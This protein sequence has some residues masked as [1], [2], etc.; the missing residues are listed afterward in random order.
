MDYRCQAA[1]P[2]TTLHCYANFTDHVASMA[3]NNR[4]T[5]NIVFAFGHMDFNKTIFFAID[6]SPK[7]FLQWF[8]GSHQTVINRMPDVFMAGYLATW[9]P[10]PGR[11]DLGNFS[12][13]YDH[14]D[15]DDARARGIAVFYTPDVLTDST[16]ERRFA[17]YSS[18]PVESKQSLANMAAKL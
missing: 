11:A 10:P 1:Q 6:N 9:T 5:N 14:I 15:V 7:P 8:D 13:G 2:H 3:A 4:G 16:A 17:A 18:T 12:V